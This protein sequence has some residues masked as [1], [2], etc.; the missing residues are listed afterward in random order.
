VLHKAGEEC[1]TRADAIGVTVGNLATIADAIRTAVDAGAMATGVL[2]D[3]ATPDSWMRSSPSPAG[4]HPRPHQTEAMQGV[5]L[6]PEAADPC[7]S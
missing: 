1:R 7:G 6:P 4:A 3:F 2:S 5:K